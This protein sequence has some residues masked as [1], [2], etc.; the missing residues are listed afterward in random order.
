M[1]CLQKMRVGHAVQKLIKF[2]SS[3]F[4]RFFIVV[5]AVSLSLLLLSSLALSV[6]IQTTHILESWI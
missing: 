6:F 1:K 5:I 4:N 2:I 3:D